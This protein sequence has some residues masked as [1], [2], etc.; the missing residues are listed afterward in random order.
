M[1]HKLL[2]ADDS[3]TI[4]KVVELVLAEE[5]FEIKSVSNG[6][7]ALAAIESFSPDIVL[8]DIE[9][10]KIN[11]YQLCEKMKQN[12]R[13]A[14]IPVILLAG[15]FEPIDEGLLRTVG[16][17]DF[18]IKPFESQELISKINA[19]LTMAAAGEEEAVVVDEGEE[20]F[21][22][23]EEAEEI[24]AAGGV[25]CAGLDE[26]LW[27]LEKVS[28]PEGQPLEA[29]EEEAAAGVELSGAEEGIREA[30]SEA[31]MGP[32]PSAE[33]VAATT[34][35][36]QI[37]MPSK[38]ELLAIFEKTVREKVLDSYSSDDIKE[39]LLAALLPSMKDSIDKVLW[40]IAPELVEKMLKETL[41]NLLESLAKEVE[42]VIWETV[43]DLANTM[44][45]REIE[46]IKS[47][48]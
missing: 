11:G 25:E 32:K 34:M 30:V 23:V 42:K 8:A 47:E 20:V 4:Q 19:A 24:P 2:L 12:P 6:E 21:E 35:A 26:D 43:P 10:P 27:D 36:S 9:M 39:S 31:A 1:A 37:V 48:F 13:T 14:G 3:I 28:A 41:K 46:R 29:F 7:D 17:D 18:I 40:E 16:A 15:A 45:S 44:I 33:A 5:D 22:I 38:E